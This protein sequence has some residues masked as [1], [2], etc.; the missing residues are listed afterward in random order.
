[1]TGEVSGRTIALGNKALMDDLKI[2]LGDLAA[3]AEALRG[4][5][6]TALFLARSGKAGAVIA[7]ADPIKATTMAALDRLRADAIRVVMLT[8][9]NATT[10]A[11]VARTLAIAE[12]HGDTLPEDK[13]R[14]VLKLKSECIGRLQ[15]NQTSAG[16]E[17]FFK[18]LCLCAINEC[19]S[20][21]EFGE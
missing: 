12:F 18:V 11:A 4:G 20:N 19:G 9:D 21:P 15:I 16:L 13:H 5:G 14:F 8:G 10:A 17:R 2:D 6:A 1:M 3:K 7:I